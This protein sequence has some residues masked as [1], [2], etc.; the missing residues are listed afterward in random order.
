VLAG[1][2]I[3]FLIVGIFTVDALKRRKRDNAWKGGWDP[4]ADE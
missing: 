2:F 4:P 1:I 3:A